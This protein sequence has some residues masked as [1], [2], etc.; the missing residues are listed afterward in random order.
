[1][2]GYTSSVRGTSGVTN[3]D[4]SKHRLSTDCR[5]STNWDAIFAAVQRE[6]YKSHATPEYRNIARELE[7]PQQKDLK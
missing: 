1:M 3:Y 5:I 6:L 2:F 7:A 4:T